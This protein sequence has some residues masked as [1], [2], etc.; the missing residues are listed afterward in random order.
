MQ[1]QPIVGLEVEDLGSGLG[2]AEGL[3][4]LSVK[5]ERVRL[6]D[7]PTGRPVA[8]LNVGARHGGW[9]FLHRARLIDLLRDGAES[10]GA[11]LRLNAEVALPADGAALSGDDLLI[12][13]PYADFGGAGSGTVY[14]VRGDSGS[15]SAKL[16]AA[17]AIID[18]LEAGDQLGASVSFAGDVDD[19]GYDD[20]WLG[21]PYRDTGGA[22]SGSAFLVFGPVSGFADLATVGNELYG[23]ASGD[24][25]GAL[26]RG[27]QDFDADGYDD[28]LLGMPG[29]ESFS[30]LLSGPWLYD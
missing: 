5:A 28:P 10:S 15:L 20:L 17:D 24:R 19:D 9:R 21:A 1:E 23:S 25:A 22:S 30:V 4:A 11:D 26:V 6:I 2:L 14:L 7:G 29:D 8:T 16:S 12:G 3:D 18:G 27:G 13:A